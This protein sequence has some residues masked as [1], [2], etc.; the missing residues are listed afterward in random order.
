MGLYQLPVI[1]GLFGNPN[2]ANKINT[3]KNTAHAYQAYRP[4]MAQAYMNELRNRA[5]ALNGANNAM[6][7]MYGQGAAFDP[8]HL[9]QQIMPPGMTSTG[10]SQSSVPSANRG[11]MFGG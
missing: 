4:E 1:G 11:G 10:V 7:L 3:I 6:A 2:A 9:N 5:G 8:S